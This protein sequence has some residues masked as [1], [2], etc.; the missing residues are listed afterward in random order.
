MAASP[1]KPQA[2]PGE[3]GGGKGLTNLQF[4]QEL[5]SFVAV[6]LGSKTTGPKRVIQV[7]VC[8]L[9]R[10]TPSLSL[11]LFLTSDDGHVHCFGPAPVMGRGEGQ[12]GGSPATAPA[13]PL[14]DDF[15]SFGASAPPSAPAFSPASQML[16]L[17][18]P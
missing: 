4:S 3:I 8:L 6:N 11:S 5:S 7:F 12:E 16:A 18:C 1:E 17:R 9:A 2:Y 10:Q 15:A 13:A 14:N